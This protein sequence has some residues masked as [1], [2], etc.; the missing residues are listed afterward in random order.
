MTSREVVR[1]SLYFKTPFRYAFDFPEKYGSD[2]FN[3]GMDPSPDGR[4][5]NG[6]VWIAGCMAVGI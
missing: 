6:G 2:F 4:M 5:S 3:C 1:A